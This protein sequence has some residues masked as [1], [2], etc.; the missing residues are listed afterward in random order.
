MS[1]N[2]AIRV[3]LFRNN[4]SQAVRLPRAVALPE[5]VKEV[6][7]SVAGKSR[8]ITPVGS[9]WDAFFDGPGVSPDFMRGRD[10][11]EDQERGG[12]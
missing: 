8:I 7:I 12:L 4:T 1:K 5:G 11:P 10:Q 3:T 2:G 9:R 6:E